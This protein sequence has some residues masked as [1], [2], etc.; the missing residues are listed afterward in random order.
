M[1][2]WSD[3]DPIDAHQRLAVADLGY[4]L[5]AELE[6]VRADAPRGALAQKEAAVAIGHERTVP[7]A[8]RQ[9]NSN[10]RAW[11]TALLNT[12]IFDANSREQKPSK[13]SRCA[14]VLAR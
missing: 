4:R 11:G 1:R 8:V 7:D 9:D 2:G 3:P 12:T 5:L 6:G 13:V 14:G 10:E